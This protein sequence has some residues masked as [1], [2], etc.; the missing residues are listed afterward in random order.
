MADL[1]IL[2]FF[3]GGIIPRVYKPRSARLQASVKIS[4]PAPPLPPSAV[5]CSNK[6]QVSVIIFLKLASYLCAVTLPH[7]AV[8]C[9]RASTLRLLLR[10]Y[11]S[12]VSS[13]LRHAYVPQDMDGGRR[14]HGT[15]G[16]GYV[17]HPSGD[18]L[19]VTDPPGGWPGHLVV[20]PP[21][22]P[23]SVPSGGT[24]SG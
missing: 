21:G 5:L 16:G 19:H 6:T 24:P 7:C 3:F 4:A 8:P 12:S 2:D 15:S 18:V 17:H 1:C 14:L 10:L 9:H 13:A 20:L 11:R 23:L 22:A